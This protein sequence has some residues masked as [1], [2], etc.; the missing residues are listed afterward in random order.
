MKIV[1]IEEIPKQSKFVSDEDLMA[2]Y[3]VCQKMQNI[4]LENGGIGLS[5]MQVG[6]PWKLF[7]YWDNF[8]NKP[9]MFSFILDAEYESSS[10]NTS[11]S[12]ESCLSL[13]NT[14]GSSRHFK[15]N[16]FD[17]IFVKGKILKYDREKPYLEI[18]EKKL[19]K[20]VFC[21][22]FQHEIDHQN[23]I[24]ISNIGEEVFLKKI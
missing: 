9:E 6:I 2:V 7:V 20:N 23:N 5:A 10:Q 14:D 24:L 18:F 21:V 4:C 3:A 8:P 12:I 1:N 11:V 17:S 13:K 15:L 19:D 16:R 22:V